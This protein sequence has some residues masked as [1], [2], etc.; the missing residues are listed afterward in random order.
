MGNKQYKCFSM[1]YKK[2]PLKHKQIALDFAFHLHSKDKKKYT[3]ILHILNGLFINIP[4]VAL[5]LKHLHCL[6]TTY[7]YFGLQMVRTL[8]SV[9]YLVIKYISNLNC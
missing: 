2:G 7:N 8:Q 1:H 3:Y 4:M 5:D 9:K 6:T